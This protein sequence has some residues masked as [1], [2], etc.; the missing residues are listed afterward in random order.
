MEKT[1][2]LKAEML[3][4]FHWHRQSDRPNETQQQTGISTMT[5]S[6]SFTYVDDLMKPLQLVIYIPIFVLGTVL[7]IL[8]LVV[9][10]FVLRKWTESTIYMTNLAL[11]DLLLLSL[12]PF[13][14]HATNHSWEAKYSLHCSFLESLYFVGMYGSIYTIACIA[15][16]RWVAICYPF[17]AKQ[18]RSPR[19]A[20]GSCIVIW[21]LVLG[22]T[23]PV[24]GFREQR[25]IPFH[26][27]HRFSEKGWNPALIC[28]LLSF[29]F[30]GPVILLV[31]CSA[32]SILALRQSGQESSK[33][34]IGVR[35]I[36]SSLFAFLVPFTPSHIGILLQFLVRRGVI[37]DCITMTRISL[38]L[39]VTMSLAN[40]TSCLD[41]IC[42]YF[43]ASEVRS[44]KHKISFRLS[45]SMSQKRATI[46]SES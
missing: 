1:M 18:L 15:A 11:M 29:G 42:Y 36:Y 23:S 10:C 22:A 19:V 12:L 4:Y 5:N 27:F 14:M 30:L 17:R 7:N 2:V 20:L 9:F 32:Q 3:H 45:R 35:I 13:K 44:S 26:C 24:Y 46:T 34:R 41:A 37:E 38:F 6:C 8:A 33:R 25:D 16:D 43:I 31:F 39:Q 21:L 40:V 28:C